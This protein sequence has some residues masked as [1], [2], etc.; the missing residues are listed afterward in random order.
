MKTKLTAIIAVTALL[1]GSQIGFAAEGNSFEGAA[2]DAWLT[3]KIETA[4]TLNEHLNPF[5]IDTHV[6]N[7]VVAL[8]G[9]VDNEIERDLAIELASGIDG[10]VEVHSNIQIE[11]GSRAAR[12]AAE[13][14]NERDFGTWFDDATTTA[15]VKSR[16][17]ANQNIK[18]LQI[19]VD[20]H[21]DEVTLSG[22]VMSDEARQ[23]AEEIAMNAKD[24]HK[25][26]N[27]LVVDA[28]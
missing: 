25:V 1:S 9:A 8:S 21:N 7:G 17:V 27:N 26:Q 16:L 14:A 11:A 15:N 10:V 5:D 28:D 22:R 23:L 19:D 3:G 12:K 24:V 4:Y 18:G 20:T 2:R 13:S 6:E